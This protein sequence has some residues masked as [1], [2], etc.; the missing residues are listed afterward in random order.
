MAGDEG[1]TFLSPEDLNR[2]LL[3]RQ[4]LLER[5]ESPLPR[6]LEQMAFL[7]A[8]YAPSMYIGL[9]SR[10]EGF[11][12]QDLTTALEDRSV[13]QGTLLRSTIHL[14]AAGDWWPASLA[15]REHRRRWWLGYHKRR[16][17][18][19][20]E[21]ESAAGRVRELLAGQPQKRAAVVAELGIDSPVWNGVNLWLDL[22]RIPPSGTW[23]HRRADLY[24][25]A[26]EWIGPC[27]PDVTE[28]LGLE[29]LL[30]RHLTGFGPAPLADVANW[31]GVPTAVLRPI[32]ERLE[33]VR[34]KDQA[35]KELLDVPGAP[36]PGG[37][38]P[39]PVRFLPTWDATLLAHA[40]RAQ[41][42][43]EHHR[44]LLFSTKN[45]QSTPSFLVDG[46][47][48]GTWRFEA[49]RIHIEPFEPLPKRARRA[50]DAEAERLL[51]LH[52]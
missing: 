51:A 7:Q 6:V 22:V 8:Q 25:L 15:V 45:P 20:T 38:T 17:S 34:S 36:L 26:E 13:V 33:L 10:V 40:R 29:L 16:P 24:A 32:T 28:D 19:L 47:V 52:R 9:W 43:A 49:G 27:P 11:R 3:G 4:L 42:L 44:P 35:D 1:A 31:A 18:A 14:V 30:R 37:D 5:A 39:A 2:A 12:R 21:V 48:A 46:R 50:V 41:V 23:E